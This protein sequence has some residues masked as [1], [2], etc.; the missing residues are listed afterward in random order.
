MSTNRLMMTRARPLGSNQK[1]GSIY[2]DYFH[3]KHYMTGM[4]DLFT[5]TFS[6]ARMTS[7]ASHIGRDQARART[8]KLVTDRLAGLANLARGLRPAAAAAR[9]VLCRSKRN[10]SRTPSVEKATLTGSCA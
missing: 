9:F 10:Q 7:A 4:S 5:E 6:H 3:S 8:E 1:A 2:D